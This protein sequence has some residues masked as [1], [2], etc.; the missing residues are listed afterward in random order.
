MPAHRP[1]PEVLIC[2]SDPLGHGATVMDPQLAFDTLLVVWVLAAALYL[3]SLGRLAGTTGW[4]K[5][6]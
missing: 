5:G 2:P 6:R 3:F 1:P 4:P